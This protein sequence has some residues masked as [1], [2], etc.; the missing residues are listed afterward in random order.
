MK[1]KKN[2]TARQIER[3]FRTAAGKIPCRVPGA[4]YRLQFNRFFLFSDARRII[5]YLHDLG[6]TDVY[7]SPFF[8]AKPGSMHGYDLT[9]Y[10]RL[11]PEVGTDEE[12]EAYVA[13]IRRLGMGQLLDIV[14][15]HMS[16][17]GSSNRWWQDV[18]ENGQS[19]PY[20]LYFDIDWKPVKEELEDKVL[21]P[22]LG[23]QY[24]RILEDGELRLSFADGAFQVNYYEQRLPLDPKSY[25]RILGP[26][27]EILAE[28]LG[29]EHEVYQELLSIITALN[30]LPSRTASDPEKM[31]ERRREKEIIKRRIADLHARN[32]QVADFIDANIKKL[33]GRK[34]SPGSFD[35]L[36]ALLADQAYRL[37]YWRVATQEI[38]YR[39]FFDI[40]DLAAVRMEHPEVFRDAHALV[41]RWVREGKV[42]G[43]RI[44]HPDGLHTP[45]AYFR[46]LQEECFM[47]MC[48]AALGVD[49]EEDGAL[50][51]FRDLYQSEILNKPESSLKRPFYLVG[52]K[53]L[54]N[55]ESMP[56]FW[57]IFGAT[58]YVFMNTV[59]RVFIDR[60]KARSMTRIYTR[61]TGELRSFAELLHQS[62]KLIMQTSMASEIHG[63]GHILNRISENDRYFR[64]ITLNSLTLAIVETIAFFPVYRTYID[65]RGVPARDRHYLDTAIARAK[66]TS[67]EVSAPVF[68]FLRDVL[69]QRYPEM[70]NETIRDQ[71]LDFTMKFQQL[72][73]PVMAKGMED[74]TFYIYNRFVSTNEVGGN[75]EKFGTTIEAFHTLNLEKLATWPHTLSATSTHDSKRS[76]DVRAR[77]NVL[78]EIPDRWQEHLRRWSRINRRWKTTLDGSPSPERNFE[79]LLYQTLIGAWPLEPMDE[80]LFT[81][82]AERIKQYMLK[83]AREA[84]TSTSWLNQNSEYEEA[85]TSF[86]GKVLQCRK[87]LE[88]FLPFQ[89]FVS[90]YGLFNSLAQALLKITVPGI[91]DFY[92]GTE[93]WAFTLVDPDNRRPVDYSARADMLAALKSRESTAGPLALADD[94]VHN[95]ADGRIKLY[96]IYKALHCRRD[97]QELFKDGEY[98]PVGVEGTHAGKIISFLRRKAAETILVV[99]PRLLTSLELDPECL[100][101]AAIWR[102]NFLLLPES[103]KTA[104]FRNV[105]TGEILQAT[106]LD[107]HPALRLPEVLSRFPVALLIKI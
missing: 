9:D 55:G 47:Q 64:D 96:L 105:F 106:A 14:P 104:T 38:N 12:F 50:A 79:Y 39:R 24:G 42:T 58:G 70:P 73:G 31:A 28:I 45:T 54:M 68:N 30:H 78:S 19:S 18:L 49:G 97:R 6:I 52:E 34:G 82:F 71:C 74:T 32:Q 25:S 7:A 57:P 2:Y 69:L 15:N 13:E 93:L 85:L 22:V 46:K 86:T 61:F 94:L 81:S 66:R 10:C 72:T 36:D 26:G 107:T 43:L 103:E 65:A 95:M 29:A 84:K 87:F 75:P 35:E 59:N 101:L 48:L 98:I 77:I 41:L 63:L 40:N 56:P 37:A 1:Q 91:P 102:D 20:A 11:N 44:D 27:L 8:L 99:V 62:K 100:P 92:Q 76:E 21:L 33:N 67:R 17:G 51:G 89:H 80:K 5:P 16:I 60:S 53:I 23:D 3:A 90:R 88:D 4:T 83:A